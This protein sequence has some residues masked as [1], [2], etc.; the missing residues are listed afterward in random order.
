LLY[1]IPFARNLHNLEPLALTLEI[2]K[3]AESKG[4]ISNTLK[5]R[6]HSNTTHTSRN[7]SSQHN[8]MSSHSTRALIAI[9]KNQRREIDVLMLRNVVGMLGVLLHV[10][11][12]PIYSPKATRSR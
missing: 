7:E 1:S 10:P 2:H 12:G 8:S 11:R 6:N 9:A 3:E 4:G 5:T